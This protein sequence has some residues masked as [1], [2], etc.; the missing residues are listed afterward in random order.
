MYLI[1]LLDEPSEEEDACIRLE[2]IR[3]EFDGLRAMQN[4]QS[5]VEF[6]S[7]DVASWRMWVYGA[8]RVLYDMGAKMLRWSYSRVPLKQEQPLAQ[9]NN[10][11]ESTSTQSLIRVVEDIKPE[12]DPHSPVQATTVSNST[13]LS[14]EDVLRTNDRDDY[15]SAVIVTTE[16]ATAAKPIPTQEDGD[17][18]QHTKDT[19]A[20]DKLSILIERFT[21]REYELEW[22]DVESLDGKTTK[23][24]HPTIMEEDE[25]DW[26]DT[27]E[28]E[29][30]NELIAAKQDEDLECG[31]ASPSTLRRLGIA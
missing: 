18:A 4:D 28:D 19:L 8:W 6:T 15:D 2:W 26:T 10:N 23:V 9:G 21:S 11:S 5:S 24:A 20:G 1:E 12:E 30:E 3:E 16:E 14:Q 13:L 22:D 29:S 17:T 7:R 25:A 27:S 31:W